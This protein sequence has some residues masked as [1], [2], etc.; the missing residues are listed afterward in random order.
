MGKWQKVHFNCAAVQ[1]HLNLR[2]LICYKTNEP[3]IHVLVKIA[4]KFFVRLTVVFTKP[5][6]ICGLF[7]YQERIKENLHN[8][9]IVAEMY[10]I[11]ISQFIC[12]I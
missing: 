9:D 5:H 10:L 11:H 4:I 7:L 1:P 3:L 8:N 6:K 12:T 2:L